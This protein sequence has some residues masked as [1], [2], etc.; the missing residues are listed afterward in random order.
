[1]SQKLIQYLS[2]NR[3]KIEI[4]TDK[5]HDLKTDCLRVDVYYMD[6]NYEVLD[7]DTYYVKKIEDI[8]QELNM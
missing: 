5:W 4:N 2:D 6:V 1:M 8:F 7:Y 3:A